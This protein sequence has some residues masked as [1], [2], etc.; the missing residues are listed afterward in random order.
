[1]ENNLKIENVIV[2]LKNI[3]DRFGNITVSEAGDKLEELLHVLRE[4]C[5]R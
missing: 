2:I 1:M 3:E 5:I 4:L